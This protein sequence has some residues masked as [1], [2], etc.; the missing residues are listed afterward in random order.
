MKAGVVSPVLA[1]LFL[2]Y[3]LDRWMAANYAQVP[4]EKYADDVI[5]HCRTEREAKEV[6]TAI[7]DGCGTVDWNF[8]R[9]RRRS[10]IARMGYGKENTPTKN[11][12]F[13]GMI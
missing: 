8:I 4:F 1:N 5:V 10:S 12:I 11:L 9:R 6:R 3:A 2:H 7:A 13:W